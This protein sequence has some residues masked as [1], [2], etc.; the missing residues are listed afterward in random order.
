[1]LGRQ[2][3]AC[4]AEQVDGAKPLSTLEDKALLTYICVEV[5]YD[6]EHDRQPAG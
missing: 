1:M 3:T 2:A 6:A 5:P 4:I